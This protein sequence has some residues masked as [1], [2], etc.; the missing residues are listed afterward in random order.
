MNSLAWQF[1][2]DLGITD[3]EFSDLQWDPWQLEGFEREPWRF[4]E[5]NTREPQDCEDVEMTAKVSGYPTMVNG[6]R[7]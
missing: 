4:E 5:E 7:V 3:W 6:L 1:P 2:G